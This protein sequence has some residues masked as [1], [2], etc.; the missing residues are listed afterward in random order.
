MTDE[1]ASEEEAV[2]ACSTSLAARSRSETVIIEPCLTPGATEGVCGAWGWAVGRDEGALEPSLASR[3]S[4]AT[5][6]TEF[7]SN[8]CFASLLMLLPP[9]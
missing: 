6:G 4:A 2:R 7:A 1:C 5:A 9:A 3:S 8:A